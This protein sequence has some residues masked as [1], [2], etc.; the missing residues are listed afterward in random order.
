MF[1]KKTIHIYIGILL[2]IILCISFIIF[3]TQY[4]IIKE[5]HYSKFK[6]KKYHMDCGSNYSPR[7]QHINRREEC[8]GYIDKL[9]CP[10]GQTWDLNEKDCVYINN[11]SHKKRYHPYHSIWDLNL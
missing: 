6:C 8:T 3:R 7:C 4:S 5:G 1:L 9:K 10:P 11:S 2:I